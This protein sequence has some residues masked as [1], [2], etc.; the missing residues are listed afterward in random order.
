MSLLEQI[1]QLCLWSLEVKAV[2]KNLD[3]STSSRLKFSLTVKYL[4]ICSAEFHPSRKHFE[5]QFFNLFE[6]FDL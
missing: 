1:A 5:G 2:Y 3:Q 6:H 4:I